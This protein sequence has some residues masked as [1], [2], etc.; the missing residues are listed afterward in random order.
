MVIFVVLVLLVYNILM[1]VG[2]FKNKYHTVGTF[3]NSNRKVMDIT[4]H[5]KVGQ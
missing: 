3:P 2:G 5:D 4:L 1:S